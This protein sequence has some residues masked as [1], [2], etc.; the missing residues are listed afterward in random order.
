[1]DFKG[2]MIVAD[3]KTDA[4]SGIETGEWKLFKPR[5]Q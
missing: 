1:V 3:K 5:R 2:G 4:V